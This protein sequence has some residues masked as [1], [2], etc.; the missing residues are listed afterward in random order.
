MD[1]IRSIINNEGGMESDYFDRYITSVHWKW[2][3]DKVAPHLSTHVIWWESEKTSH[4]F[5]NSKKQIG[6]TTKTHQREIIELAEQTCLQFHEENKNNFIK[7]RKGTFSELIIRMM[8]RLLSMV[9]QS[10]SQY[11]MITEDLIEGFKRNETKEHSATVTQDKIKEV[12]VEYLAQKLN[13]NVDKDKGKL[14]KKGHSLPRKEKVETKETKEDEEEEDEEQEDKEIIIVSPDATKPPRS[15][16]KT[17][18]PRGRPRGSTNTTKSIPTLP[19][20][21]GR[22]RGRP[23][24]SRKTKMGLDDRSS[25]S[26]STFV[27]P[28][29]IR[30]KRVKKPKD[31]GDNEEDVEDDEDDLDFDIDFDDDD[32]SNATG[33][34]K[35][36]VDEGVKS[37]VTDLLG[38][39]GDNLEEYSTLDDNDEQSLDHEM[40]VET[41]PKETSGT[42]L[43]PSTINPKNNHI[44]SEFVRKKSTT[45]RHNI[46]SCYRTNQK[47]KIST[48][49]NYKLPRGRGRCKGKGINKG[50]KT[51]DIFV[52]YNSHY[53]VALSIQ[54]PGN[55]SDENNRRTMYGHQ[56][57]RPVHSEILN[58]QELKEYQKSIKDSTNHN[59]VD[60]PKNKNQST[61]NT[62]EI[63]DNLIQELKEDVTIPTPLELDIEDLRTKMRKQV[64][65]ASTK[66]APNPSSS[67]STTSETVGINKV[68]ETLKDADIPSQTEWEEMGYP[69]DLRSDGSI[70][71]AVRLL[72]LRL[73]H[74]DDDFMDILVRDMTIK[75]RT[76]KK[77]MISPLAYF[78]LSS[79]SLSFLASMIIDYEE[80]DIADFALLRRSKNILEHSQMDFNVIRL[81][82]YFHMHRSTHSYLKLSLQ[83][84]QKQIFA[85]KRKYRVSPSVDIPQ[86]FGST[87]YCP[88]TK[89]IASVVHSLTHTYAD[90]HVDIMRHVKYNSLGEDLNN[91]HSKTIARDEVN[92]EIYIESK[93]RDG[94]L[95]DVHNV[96]SKALIFDPTKR[97]QYFK[98]KKRRPVN[99]NDATSG[100]NQLD[101]NSDSEEVHPQKEGDEERVL[102]PENINDT[103]KE[104]F[105]ETRE[106]MD[107][108]NQVQNG[109]QEDDE[110]NSSSSPREPIPRDYPIE[111]FN[112]LER[113][114]S[115]LVYNEN[116][117]LQLKFETFLKER[118][119]AVY[120][121]TWANKQDFLNHIYEKKDMDRMKKVFPDP[122]QVKILYEEDHFIILY[123][124][125]T[126]RQ[127]AYIKN[128]LRTITLQYNKIQQ[129]HSY[130]QEYESPYYAIDLVGIVKRLGHQSYTLCC[131]CGNVTDFSLDHTLPGTGDIYCGIHKSHMKNPSTK[132]D[133]LQN[134]KNAIFDWTDILG[135]MTN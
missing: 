56:D 30:S 122:K 66:G 1:R 18:R 132:K 71:K 89:K 20:T 128:E 60:D 58:A 73:P 119:L 64:K 112:V 129:L 31:Q 135:M 21:R 82:I 102:D 83:T 5:E 97:V 22:G 27:A 99:S 98:W 96:H 86:I 84:R 43:I 91:T 92:H 75:Y 29:P 110:Q 24:G 88:G 52:N 13:I 81:Y 70:G 26:T 80:Y 90:C 2:R 3:R 115:Y 36:I 118:M 105:G 74:I 76:T 16:G 120:G 101:L 104:N 50:R 47:P 8:K 4:I 53:P 34:M 87:N 79:N 78:G 69:E 19:K 127:Y 42:S 65:I 55:V 130:R 40:D 126:K 44:P 54:S 6:I 125:V 134:E 9:L 35:D 113:V 23:R 32:N 39:D 103:L 85:L 93:Q 117:E 15:R 62:F 121:Q 46:S 7:L 12:N 100:R 28:E 95:N 114:L 45:S 59:H 25:S 72:A 41:L 33:I 68:N 57:Y 37:M 48:M 109:Q 11:K 123:E 51:R 61:D 106:K 63:L 49:S 38:D 14:N 131:K 108:I 10:A 107:F 111:K 17:G 116:V 124:P 94:M 77:I 67:S 133:A